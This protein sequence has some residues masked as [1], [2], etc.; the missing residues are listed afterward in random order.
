MDGLTQ[1]IQDGKLEIRGNTEVF[2]GV[3]QDLVVGANNVIDAFMVPFSVAA[4]YVDRISKGDIPD[5]ITDEY[6]GDFN[7]IKKKMNLL[8]EAMNDLT[9]MDEE[10]DVGN[11][12]VEVKER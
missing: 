1:A 2:E 7:E 12:T 9:W 4:A 3:W 8:I 11:L 6:N 5:T 10:M